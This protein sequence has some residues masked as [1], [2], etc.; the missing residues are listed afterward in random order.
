MW[1]SLKSWITQCSGTTP[2]RPTLLY[3]ATV[4]GF[5][6]ANFHAAC[7]DKPRLLVIARNQAGYMFGGF[8]VVPFHSC[9]GWIYENQSFLFSLVNHQ[10]AKPSMFPICIRNAGCAL[11]YRST[12]IA[13]DNHLAILI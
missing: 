3:T 13:Y 2:F 5:G 4:D 6:A 7:D 11:A 9:S 12:C 8:S 10:N 1:Y